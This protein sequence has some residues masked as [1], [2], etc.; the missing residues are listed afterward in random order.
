MNQLSSTE[1]IPSLSEMEDGAGEFEKALR[2]FNREGGS[3][4]INYKMKKTGGTS[5]DESITLIG[6]TSNTAHLKITT[7]DGKEITVTRNGGRGTL[8]Y[9]QLEKKLEKIIGLRG[10]KLYALLNKTSSGGLTSYG[11]AEN[12]DYQKAFLVK[13]RLP[14]GTYTGDVKYTGTLTVRPKQGNSNEH[15]FVFRLSVEGD[16]RSAN[17]ED[18]TS[19]S[20]GTGDSGNPQSL[21]CTCEYNVSDNANKFKVS[22]LT[23]SMAMNMHRI[24]QIESDGISA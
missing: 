14:N 6:G 5:V 13:N 20:Y 23:Y 8:S 16:V 2:S 22:N 19:I 18:G 17:L 15:K 3:L 1:Y 21:T 7:A 10:D 11:V 4:T 9:A 12:Q 24:V